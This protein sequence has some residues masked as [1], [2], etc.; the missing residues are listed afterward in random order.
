MTHPANRFAAREARRGRPLFALGGI[1]LCWIG[2]RALT[3]EMPPGWDEAPVPSA[4]GIAELIGARAPVGPGWGVSPAPIGTGA[5]SRIVI[6]PAR[7]A[8]A[9][10]GVGSAVRMASLPATLPLVPVPLRSAS[11]PAPPSMQTAAGHN[12]LWMAAMRAIPL[13]ADVAVAFNRAIEREGAIG[14]RPDS[15]APRERRWGA[16]VWAMLREGVT[17]F[18]GGIAPGAVYGGSQS[19][20][21][22]RYRLAPASP[23]R[24]VAYVRAVQALGGTREADLAAGFAMRPIPGVPLTAHA[25]IRASR[26]GAIL[27]SRPAAFLAAGFDELR[28][29]AGLSARGYAQA[30]YIGGSNATGFADGSVAAERP[31][32][33]AERGGLLAAGVGAWGG[34][35]RGANRLDL[36]PSASM[37]FRLGEGTARISADYRLR[38]AGNAAPAASAGLT[39]TAGF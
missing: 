29:P 4:R 37:R 36:G 21:V 30:G 39:F 25:E 16:D 6:S 38:V 5:V 31:L 3:F 9:P 12:L 35:Q 7:P 1:L 2:A 11:P 18:A 10:A 32:W 24:P 26:R 27:E 15:M 19:G 23:I 34:A 22:I 20:A 28:L 8:A 14:R 33:Q 17:G 13:P